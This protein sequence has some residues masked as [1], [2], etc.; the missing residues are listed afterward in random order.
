MLSLSSITWVRCPLIQRIT[1]IVTPISG[2][3]PP[4]YPLTAPNLSLCSNAILSHMSKLAD[5]RY[6]AL[7]LTKAILRALEYH[8]LS[9]GPSSEAVC[10]F[11]TI[12]LGLQNG[13]RCIKYWHSNPTS[14]SEQFCKVPISA[15]KGTFAFYPIAFI[16]D[17]FSF[18]LESSHFMYPAGALAKSTYLRVCFC[19]N[20]GFT[21][22]IQ[23]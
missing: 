9:G 10:I 11:D 4:S 5:I 19:F 7:P 3:L 15:Y 1:V 18:L 13:S 14:Q 23:E 12:C 17:N 16:N 2:T 6:E 8:S 20:K 22:N 21:G